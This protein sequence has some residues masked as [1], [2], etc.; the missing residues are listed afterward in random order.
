MGAS[1]E[2]AFA[3]DCLGVDFEIELCR[4][5][6]G[7]EQPQG[8]LPKS[9]LGIYNGPKKSLSDPAGRREDR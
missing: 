5:A 8:I 9:I 3:E 1:A 4:Q 2:M 7:S 6:H